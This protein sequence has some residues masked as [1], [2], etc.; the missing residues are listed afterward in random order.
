MIL[1]YNPSAK[2]D[3]LPLVCQVNQIPTTAMRLAEMPKTICMIASRCMANV[4][5]SAS[6]RELCQDV[7]GAN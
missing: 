5:M 4:C 6:G 2:D 7:D 3:D 1:G